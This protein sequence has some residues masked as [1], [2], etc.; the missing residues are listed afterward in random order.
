MTGKPK[1]DPN[2]SKMGRPRLEIDY[3][4]LKKLCVLQCTLEEIAGWFE[5]S[6][7]TIERRIKEQYGVTFAEYYAKASMR[8]KIHIRRKQMQ[9]AKSGNVTM[10][11]WLGKQYLGQKENPAPQVEDEFDVIFE[12][13]GDEKTQAPHQD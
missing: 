2:A 5:V 10:L 6:P 7:D 1:L 9:V 3:E 13:E 11:I 12:D 4:I 8:G